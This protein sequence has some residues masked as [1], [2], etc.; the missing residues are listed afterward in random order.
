MSDCKRDLGFHRKLCRR[1]PFFKPAHQRMDTGIRRF[2]GAAF[3][4]GHRL[5]H[6]H[7]TTFSTPIQ[8][9]P[10]TEI[11]YH[12]ANACRHLSLTQPPWGC[13]VLGRPATSTTKAFSRKLLCYMLCF[14][15]WNQS[16]FKKPDREQPTENLRH[17]LS[18]SVDSSDHFSCV[19]ITTFQLFHQPEKEGERGMSHREF[20]LCAEPPYHHSPS[21]SKLILRTRKPE[22]N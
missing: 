2:T 3:R 17:F 21:P 9:T 6:I 19:A 4:Q 22:K 7:E 16:V 5:Q 11:Q 15:L 8:V 10:P 1:L 14:K 20:G 12:P 13:R 18:F